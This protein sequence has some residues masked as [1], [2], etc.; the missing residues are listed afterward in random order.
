MLPGIDAHSVII[1]GADIKWL[2]DQPDNVLSAQAMQRELI[3]SDHSFLDPDIARNTY[4]EVTI[5]RDLTRSIGDLIPDIE[6]ELNL[7]AD[8]YWGVDTHNWNEI[9]VMDTV[10]KMV[11][12]TSN[13]IFV[14]TSLCEFDF[15]LLPTCRSM[16]TIN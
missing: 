7:G 14:G 4:Q 12:R 10:R 1:P 2:L 9:N 3:Q 5:R 15:P 11:T 8:K 13:R 6:D 16:L